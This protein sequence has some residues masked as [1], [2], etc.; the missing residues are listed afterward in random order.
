MERFQGMLDFHGGVH[1]V[2]S[3]GEQF[4]YFDFVPNKLMSRSGLIKRSF[5]QMYAMFKTTCSTE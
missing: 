1:Y 5:H 3:W 2:V 4:P